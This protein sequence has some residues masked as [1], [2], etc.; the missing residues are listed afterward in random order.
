MPRAQLSQHVQHQD[1]F[2]ETEISPL[3]YLMSLGTPSTGL[4]LPP[5]FY[6]PNTRRGQ[7]PS[8]SLHTRVP[9]ASSLK[10][11]E[12]ASASQ[13]S[14]LPEAFYELIAWP[15]KI[16][17]KCSLLMTYLVTSPIFWS[18]VLTNKFIT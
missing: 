8:T 13:L 3:S 16:L 9:Q 12:H 7:A 11:S 6:L 5:A 18:L 10:Y 1:S 2:W 17:N 15:P 14:K 4:G